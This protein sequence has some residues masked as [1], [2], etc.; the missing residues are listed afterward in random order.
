MDEIQPTRSSRKHNKEDPHKNNTTPSL[1]PIVHGSPLVTQKHEHS[2]ASG[3]AKTKHGPSAAFI[4][5]ATSG[6]LY[7]DDSDDED[8]DQRYHRTKTMGGKI[9]EED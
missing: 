7:D 4:R 1:P 5:T 3:F 6:P 2:N 8:M 9:P